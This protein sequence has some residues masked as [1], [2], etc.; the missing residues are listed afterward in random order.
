MRTDYERA[1]PAS[2]A[3]VPV[4]KGSHSRIGHAP[5]DGKWRV[6]LKPG[7]D[8]IREGRTLF[9]GT[10]RFVEETTRLLKPGDYQRKLGRQ[11]MKG[12]WKGYP[13]FSLTLEER[14]TCPSSCGHWLSCYG[15]NMH[16]AQRIVHDADFE[17]VLWL[18]LE[19]L[20]KAHPLGFVVRLHILGDFYSVGY[21][22]LWERALVQFP[23]LN[24]FGYTARDPACKDD[25]IGRELKRLSDQHWSRFALRFSGKDWGLQG[26][27]TVDRGERVAGAIT[28]PAQTGKTACCATCGLCWMAKATIAF[29]RH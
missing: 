6:N 19:A 10:V 11:V 14:K 25:G 18:E 29:E 26:A 3:Q 13:I 23:A 5:N 24:V 9:P 1:N 4:P 27:I 15:N 7:H 21:V 22:K 2:R 12:P 20:N 16:R 17:E 8:A 28:C